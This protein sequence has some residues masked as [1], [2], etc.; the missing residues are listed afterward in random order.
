MWVRTGYVF[1]ESTDGERRKCPCNRD[2]VE[3]ALVPTSVSARLGDST[4]A[5][6]FPDVV[7]AQFFLMLF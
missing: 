2:P 6:P 5:F 1:Q 4:T 3:R 7:L